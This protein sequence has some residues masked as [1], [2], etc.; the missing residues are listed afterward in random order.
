MEDRILHLYKMTYDNNV[1]WS[2]KKNK[3]LAFLPLLKLI[4]LTYLK[5]FPLE[6]AV[7]KKKIVLCLFK[8][9]LLCLRW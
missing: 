2:I 6:T 8:K 4:I 9:Y 3:L 5:Y 7:D 1:M